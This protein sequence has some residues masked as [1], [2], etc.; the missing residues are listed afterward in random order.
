M[1]SESLFSGVLS[2]SRGCKLQ[3]CCLRHNRE[4]YIRGTLSRDIEG[5]KNAIFHLKRGGV[6]FSKLSLQFLN[7]LSFLGGRT[8]LR[9]PR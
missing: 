2:Q 3:W 7:F 1:G 8:V 5:G 6:A 4:E 9:K